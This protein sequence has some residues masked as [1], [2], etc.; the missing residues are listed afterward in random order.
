MCKLQDAVVFLQVLD[1]AVGLPSFNFKYR[2][3]LPLEA[4]LGSHDEKGRR[5]GSSC[6]TTSSQTSANRCACRC[7]WCFCFYVDDGWCCFKKRVATNSRENARIL[8][9]GLGLRI[10]TDASKLPGNLDV[11]RFALVCL[12]LGLQTAF[13]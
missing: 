6:W 5:W 9:A 10:C 12:D 13:H 3:L 2:I 4:L 8:T 7:C 1:L 11:E